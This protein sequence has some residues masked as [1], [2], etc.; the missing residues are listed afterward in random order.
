MYAINDASFAIQPALKA[1][2]ERNKHPYV[3]IHIYMYVNSWIVF[4]R[5][6]IGWERRLS[7]TEPGVIVCKRVCQC[8]LR[9]RQAVVRRRQQ[10]V[11]QEQRT[12]S[13]NESD[14]IAF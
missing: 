10:V 5:A 1:V 11:V 14:Y 8:C 13:V 12:W 6:V 4:V 2:S 3:L 9:S 7:K